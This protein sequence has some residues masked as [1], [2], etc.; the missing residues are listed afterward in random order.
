MEA[1]QYTK[2]LIFQHQGTKTLC[3]VAYSYNAL[4][5]EVYELKCINIINI[6]DQVDLCLQD[7]P[8]SSALLRMVCSN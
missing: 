2:T 8:N 1:W 6:W 3:Y 7:C 5:L 4:G